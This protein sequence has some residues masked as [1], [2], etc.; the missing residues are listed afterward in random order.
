MSLTQ[1][2]IEN[3]IVETGELDKLLKYVST[4]P[5]PL[6]DIMK[7]KICEIMQELRD[8]ELDITFFA[9]IAT[10]LEARG[11]PESQIKSV[12]MML[13]TVRKDE[14]E[15][16]RTV[17]VGYG[18]SFVS[19]LLDSSRV[20]EQGPGKLIQIQLFTNGTNNATLS[21]FDSPDITHCP[22]SSFLFALHCVGANLYTTDGPGKELGFTALT[23]IL[24]GEGSSFCVEYKILEKGRGG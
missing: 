7:D 5:L 13:A 9:K 21:L 8:Q 6:N 14:R 23:A 2:S 11:L 20:L 4:S 22:A 10:I 17:V 12:L 1:T 3:I 15:R 16:L 24:A 19:G 18:G